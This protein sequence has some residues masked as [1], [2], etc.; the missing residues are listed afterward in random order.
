MVKRLPVKIITFLFVVLGD[1]LNK[2]PTA[3][4]V[5]IFLAKMLQSRFTELDTDAKIMSK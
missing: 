4:K 1:C 5:E 3:R 2:K